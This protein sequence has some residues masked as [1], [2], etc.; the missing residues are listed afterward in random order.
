MLV[1]FHFYLSVWSLY[2]CI[3]L[4]ISVSP[5]VCPPVCPSVCLSS[6]WLLA[7]RLCLSVCLTLCL[8]VFLFVYMFVCLCTCLSVWIVLISKKAPK[9][10]QFCQIRSNMKMSDNL[11]KYEVL[12]EQYLRSILD[13]SVLVCLF[14]FAFPSI[15]E[16]KAEKRRKHNAFI[17]MVLLNGSL[18]FER[19]RLYS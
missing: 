13:I 17:Y 9:H 5:F 4:K 15:A 19:F 7:V 18:Y 2:V 8:S 6:V 10:T 16:K 14:L 1:C 3:S 12:I 11:T